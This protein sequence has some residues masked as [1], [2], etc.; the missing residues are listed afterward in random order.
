MADQPAWLKH[1]KAYAARRY[2]DN[3]AKAAVLALKGESARGAVVLAT[4][5]VEDA[6]EDKL[7]ELMPVL[8]TDKFARGKVFGFEGAVGTF[9]R[10]SLM[11]YALGLIDKDEFDFIE[12]LREMRNACAHS[13]ADIDFETP[14]LLAACAVALAPEMPHLKDKSAVALRQV[15]VFKC[16]LMAH[17][18]ATG[19][20]Q[21][22]LEHLQAHQAPPVRES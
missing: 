15:F 22:V 11:A 7:G 14:E 17:Q 2:Q 12:V 10:K 8:E 13:R 18:L 9:S 20:R 1:L 19:E 4:T 5:Q 16:A 3:G 21:S 6:L